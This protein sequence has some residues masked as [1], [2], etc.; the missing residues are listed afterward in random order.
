[1]RNNRSFFSFCTLVQVAENH[2]DYCCER[3]L[4]VERD[5]STILVDFFV[6]SIRQPPLNDVPKKE[7]EEEMNKTEDAIQGHE[8]LWVS[9]RRLE[10]EL[11]S[12]EEYDE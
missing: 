7:K 3:A 10:Q 1:M 9:L 6:G 5:C 4:H 12:V 2:E 11:R 8:Q